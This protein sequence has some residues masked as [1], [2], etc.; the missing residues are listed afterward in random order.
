MTSAKES[1]SFPIPEYAFSSL[2]EKPS[3]KSKTDA[4]NMQYTAYWYSPLKVN[5]MDIAPERR[6]QQVIVF[7]ICFVIFILFDI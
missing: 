3:K 5:M 4:N 7:G 6:L 1:S 2:A